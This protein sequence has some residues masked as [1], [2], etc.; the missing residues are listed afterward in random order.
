MLVH[1]TAW[2]RLILEG[3]G[4]KPFKPLYTLGSSRAPFLEK[5]L[6]NIDTPG[7]PN[8]LPLNGGMWVNGYGCFQKTEFEAKMLQCLLWR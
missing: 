6:H 5:A 7:H 3:A 2:D 1:S 4:S 8:E